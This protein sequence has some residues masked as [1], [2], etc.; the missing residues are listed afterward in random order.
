MSSLVQS[1]P[2]AVKAE[3][4]TSPPPLIALIAIQAYV[5]ANVYTLSKLCPALQQTAPQYPGRCHILIMLR[6]LPSTRIAYAAAPLL[7]AAT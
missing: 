1:I 2:N 7:P 4:Q 3:G 5:H 6:P